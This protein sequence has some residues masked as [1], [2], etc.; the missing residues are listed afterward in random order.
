MQAPVSAAASHLRCHLYSAFHGPRRLRLR[1]GL[2]AMKRYHLWSA[3]PSIF[4]AGS[5]L[6]SGHSPMKRC[7]PCAPSISNAGSR[8]RSGLPSMKRYHLWSA[9]PSISY[10]GYHLSINL[11]FIQRPL[12]YGTLPFLQGL[13]CSKNDPFLATASLL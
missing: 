10:A 7:H 4:H 8:L 1:S 3:A 13:P 11:L 6:R 5:R 9:A 12:N 2:L